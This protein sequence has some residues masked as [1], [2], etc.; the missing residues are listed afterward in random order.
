M[1]SIEFHNLMLDR[2]LITP[3]NGVYYSTT[4]V[5]DTFPKFLK[6]IGCRTGAEIGV[7]RGAYTRMFAEELT[8]TFYAID[9]WVCWANDLCS[10]GAYRMKSVEGSIEKTEQDHLVSEARLEKYNHVKIL[11]MTSLQASIGIPDESLDMVYVDGN[12]KY[13]F[14]AIDLLSFWSK[15]RNGGI[16]SG[17]DHNFSTV[18]KAVDEFI[19]RYKVPYCYIM[20]GERPNSF[21]FIKDE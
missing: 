9:P 1:T 6:S 10:G 5:R 13:H 17:H 4:L 20:D 3:L 18:K 8:G 12:H 2:K 11:R 7:F 16:M 19:K 21:L 15:L 14:V